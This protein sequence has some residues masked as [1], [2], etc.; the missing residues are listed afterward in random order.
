MVRLRYFK[1]LILSDF[2]AP[3]LTWNDELKSYIGYASKYRDIV[4]YFKRSGVK[5]E[6]SVLDLLPFP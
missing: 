2:S 1:G 6:D 4:F 5:V 3:S